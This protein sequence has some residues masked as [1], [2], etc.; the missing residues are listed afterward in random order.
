MSYFIKVTPE[1]D[2]FLTHYKIITHD[3]CTHKTQK[4]LP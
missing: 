1:F 4:E 2:E 3:I